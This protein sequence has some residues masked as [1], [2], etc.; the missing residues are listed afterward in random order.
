MKKT[1]ILCVDKMVEELEL[2]DT[3]GGNVKWITMW[4]TI[5]QFLKKKLSIHLTYDPA[6]L[7]PDVYPKGKEAHV[8]ADLRAND[9]SSCLWSQTENNP[10]NRTDEWIN[11]LLYIHTWNTTSLIKRNGLLIPAI[12]QM[13]FKIIMQSERRQK[14]VH[15]VWVHLYKIL[16]KVNV[17]YRDRK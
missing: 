9:Q 5:R 1:T 15:T 11:P 14:V 6:I 16:E 10:N 4:K 2:S 7:L 17:I 12:M 3:A 8:Q 13:P